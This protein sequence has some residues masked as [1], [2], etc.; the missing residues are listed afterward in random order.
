MFF[1]VLGLGLA[2]GLVYTGK[3][4][5]EQWVYALAI[6]I[7]GHHAEDIIKAWKGGGT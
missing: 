6:V 5:G 2:T 7:A 4:G 3:L 1:S